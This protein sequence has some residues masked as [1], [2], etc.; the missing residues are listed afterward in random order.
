ML[1]GDC[2]IYGSIYANNW[3]KIEDAAYL[4][5][6]NSEGLMVFDIVQV[7]QYDLWAELKRAIDKSRY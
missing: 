5:L 3:K 7:I 2:K 1:Y 4:C 6:K